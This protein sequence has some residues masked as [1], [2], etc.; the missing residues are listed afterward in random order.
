MQGHL[1]ESTEDAYSM[2]R[3]NSNAVNHI[4]SKKLSRKSIPVGRG[5]N[6]G[7]DS[8]EEENDNILN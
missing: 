5:H 7:D 3:I 6:L 8:S 2:I 1:K 4:Q